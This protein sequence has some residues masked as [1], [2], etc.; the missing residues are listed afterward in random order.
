MTWS[1]YK[2]IAPC[3]FALLISFSTQP[4]TVSSRQ[5]SCRDL[6][7]VKKIPTPHSKINLLETSGGNRW[8]LKQ[9]IRTSVYGQA[10]TIVETLG[11]SIAEALGIPCNKVRLMGAQD[12]C[13]FKPHKASYPATFHS[14]VPGTTTYNS[15]EFKDL[16]ISQR[17]APQGGGRICGLTRSIIEQMARHPDL[18]P[19]VA[20]DT[21]V[22]SKRSN[23]NL[24]YDYKDDTFYAIDYGS[25]FRATFAQ[26]S[27]NNIQAL[28]PHML[29][30][31]EVKALRVYNA[32]LKKL[33]RLYTA[34]GLCR[35]LDDCVKQSGLELVLQSRRQRRS[36]ELADYLED[37]K[38]H[39]RVNYRASQ[40][41]VQAIEEYVDR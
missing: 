28:R 7:F 13:K 40:L 1:N 22:G 36:S 8:L 29:S 35:Q 20:V 3:S 33:L 39:I 19:L 25:S 21:F 31:R 11:T 18:P 15:A 24:M 12:T 16:H 17:C 6:S 10:M 26:A 14:F 23:Q 5:P 41:L 2:L 32:T 38:K 37:V 34:E 30:P 9:R 27:L 4:R